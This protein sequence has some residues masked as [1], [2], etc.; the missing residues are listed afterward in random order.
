VL[1][2]VEPFFFYER[3]ELSIDDESRRSVMGKTAD[4]ED[5]HRGRASY[6]PILPSMSYRELQPLEASEWTPAVHSTRETPS[7]LIVWVITVAVCGVIGWGVAG[8]WWGAATAGVGAAGLWTWIRLKG[9]LVRQS[10]HAIKLRPEQ[11]PR[12][13]NIAAGLAGRVHGAVPAIWLV[14]DGGP[15]AL[16]CWAGGPCIA[17][18]QSLLDGYTRTELEAVV[19][20]CLVRLRKSAALSQALTF[21]R[22]RIAVSPSD[23]LWRDAATA[24]LTRYPPALATA[25]TKAQPR[26]DRFAPLWFVSAGSGQADASARIELLQDL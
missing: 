15:N 7:S 20:Y 4:A 1:V 13:F 18:T 2:A 3:D 14:P 24:A 8:P 26:S 6:A 11:A 17:I 16:V 19:A 5:L 9:R 10:L 21:G 22:R 25:I 23:V 12:L